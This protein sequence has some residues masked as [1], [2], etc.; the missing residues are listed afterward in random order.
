MLSS[1]QPT[2]IAWSMWATALVLAAL[3]ALL[4]SLN[5]GHSNPFSFEYWLPNVVGGLS[6]STV[7]TM[8]VSRRPENAIG[9]LFAV[10]GIGSLIVAVGGEYAAYSLSTSPGSLPLGGIAAWIANLALGF[11]WTTLFTFLLLLF[12]TGEPLSPRWRPLVWVAAAV[13]VVSVVAMAVRPGPL[14]EPFQF[15]LNPLGVSHPR[16][17][18]DGTKLVSQILEPIPLF[19]GVVAVVSLILRLRRSR[20]IERQQLK[21]FVYSIASFIVL[22]IAFN[23]LLPLLS[24]SQSTGDL[25]GTILIVA[26]LGVGLPC[27]VAVA[28]LRYRLYDI[29]RIINKTLV[30]GSLTAILV[31]AD[32][33]LVIGLEHLLEP[34]A[35]GSSLIVAGSTLAVA[36]LVRPLR[37]RVQTTV[38][39]RFYRHKYDAARTLE[40]FSL[41]LRDQTNLAELATELGSVVHETM[42][43]THVSLWLR[44]RKAL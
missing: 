19:I 20:G 27:A 33:L 11:V 3:A 37:S 14:D 42:Q 41:R 2:H 30:Y 35:S 12:P 38:D 5:R 1:E 6:M 28:I 29:D 7:G 26:L 32:V 22:Y 36:A 13:L 23:S 40:A 10:E 17:F 34:V 43:P 44:N 16:P 24:V 8:I 25:I 9:R 15:V 18:A 21:W 31:G 39:R 4:L